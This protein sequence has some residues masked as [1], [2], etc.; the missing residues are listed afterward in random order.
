MEVPSSRSEAPPL[1]A[2]DTV[3]GSGRCHKLQTMMSGLYLHAMMHK[4]A[5]SR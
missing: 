3:E 2:I 4:A 1:L 5:R